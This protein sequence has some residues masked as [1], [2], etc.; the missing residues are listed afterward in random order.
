MASLTLLSIS[1]SIDF[2]DLI[3][4]SSSGLSAPTLAA[5][6]KHKKLY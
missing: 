3:P 6:L 1:A 5:P 4:V 2:T